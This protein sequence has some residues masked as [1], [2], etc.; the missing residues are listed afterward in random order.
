MNG[1]DHGKSFFC[2]QYDTGYHGMPRFGDEMSDTQIAELVNYVRGN[3]GN[4]FPDAATAED[5]TRMRGE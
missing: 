2:S 1:G 3:F 5:V 4:S